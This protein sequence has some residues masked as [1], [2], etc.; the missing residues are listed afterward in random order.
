[1]RKPLEIRWHGRGGQGVVTASKVLAEA[2]LQAGKYFQ[3]FPEYGPERMGAPVRAYNRVSDQPIRIHCGV[4]NP[5][6]VIV[7]DPTLLSSGD[8]LDGLVPGGTVIAN[9][10]GTPQELREKLAIKNGKVVTVDASGISREILGRVVVNT[11]ML[12][13]LCK[14]FDGVSLEVVADAVKHQFGEKLRQEIIDKNIACLKRAYEEAQ[15][16]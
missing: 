3:A 11:P 13:A 6:F 10:E 1:L 9:F 8:I 4:T 7:V 14:V 16:A 2:L 5:E 12:G 15:I